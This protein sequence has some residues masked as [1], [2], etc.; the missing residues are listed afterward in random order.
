VRET[1]VKAG[2]CLGI[3]LANLVAV[4]SLRRILIAGSVTCFGP[5][6]LDVMQ[7]EMIRRSLAP[8]ARE[9]QLGLSS[10]GP[11]MVILGASA[12]VLTRELGL[13]A[14]L[15]NQFQYPIV[16]SRE[17]EPRAESQ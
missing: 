2:R 16:A 15:V 8:V 7:Q 12:L 11:D 9:T 13:F 14:P 1:V 10:M 17:N 5:L 3:A 4:L 6:L